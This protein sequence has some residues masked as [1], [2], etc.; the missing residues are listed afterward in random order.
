MSGIPNDEDFRRERDG[1]R[2]R[3]ASDESLREISLETQMRTDAYKFGY[4]FEWMGVPVIRFPDDILIFQEIVF[5][6]RPHLTVEV[7]VARGGGALL[8][9]SLMSLYDESPHVLGLDNDIR[10]HCRHAIEESKF[11]EIIELWEVDSASKE[12]QQL[13][14]NAVALYAR[15]APVVMTLDSNHTHDHVF[16]ELRNFIPLLPEQSVVIV[17]DAIIE[18]CPQGH[19]HDRPWGPGNSPKS[20]LDEYLKVNDRVKLD[21]RWCRRG[22]LT[23]CR[24]SIILVGNSQ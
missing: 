14:D 18:E 19:F 5:T 10:P 12:A 8:A 6:V 23:E 2:T 9:A 20:A 13:V 24:D 11:N 16:A 4:Q 17:A 7:G 1:W 21:S 3:M 15:D 22:V